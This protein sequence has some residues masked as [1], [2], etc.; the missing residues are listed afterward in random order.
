MDHEGAARNPSNDSRTWSLEVRTTGDAAAAHADK[1]SRYGL[2]TESEP[3]GD[4][5][6]GLKDFNLSPAGQEQ[7]AES[8]NRQANPDCRSSLVERAGPPVNWIDRGMRWA[9]AGHIDQHVLLELI[10]KAVLPVLMTP[11][12][13]P[14]T[15]Q[16]P[17]GPRLTAFAASCLVPD[18]VRA[19]PMYV[20]RLLKALPPDAFLVVNG[21]AELQAKFLVADLVAALRDIGLLVDNPSGG[22]DVGPAIWVE[23]SARLTELVDEPTFDA[24]EQALARWGK[25]SETTVPRARQIEL[26][27]NAVEVLVQGGIA[28]PDVLAATAAFRGVE[29]LYGGSRTIVISGDEETRAR[30]ILRSATSPREPSSDVNPA[31]AEVVADLVYH[32]YVEHLRAMP[33]Q[34][35]A[36]VLAN[37]FA[38]AIT[39]WVQADVR[40]HR[41]SEL[42]IELLTCAKD[43]P[44]ELRALFAERVTGLDP[45]RPAPYKLRPEPRLSITS[46]DQAI[47]CAREDLGVL[48]DPVHVED[49]GPAYLVRSEADASQVYFVH[50]VWETVTIEDDRRG[51]ARSYCIKYDVF[52]LD[53]KW[54][55][56]RPGFQ[57][58]PAPAQMPIGAP[59]QVGGPMQGGEGQTDPSRTALSDSGLAET[60]ASTQQDADGD[61][62]ADAI[63]APTLIG[64]YSMASGD[65]P[66]RVAEFRWSTEAGVTVEVFDQE[67]GKVA[68]YHYHRGVSLVSEKRDVLPSEGPEFMRALLKRNDMSYYRFVDESAQD[69]PVSR[70][71]G[72]AEVDMSQPQGVEMTALEQAIARFSTGQGPVEDVYREFLVARTFLITAPDSSPAYFRIA[73]QPKEQIWVCTD[74]SAAPDLG[75]PE[76]GPTGT[77]P[78][79][80]YRLLPLLADRNVRILTRGD[81]MDLMIIGSRAV[82]LS[83]PE[84][85]DQ[86]RAEGLKKPGTW[87][88]VPDRMLREKPWEGVPERHVVGEY[89]VDENGT[90][91]DQYRPNPA[92]RPSPRTLGFPEPE[93]RLEHFLQLHVTD[94]I[95][96][97]TLVKVL[98]QS[99]IVL[100]AHE[101]GVPAAFQLGDRP[102][103]V[104]ASASEHIPGF[105]KGK[106]KAT[107]AEMTPAFKETD[108][109]IDLGTRHQTHLP[110]QLLLEVLASLEQEKP[111]DAG[112]QRPA[113]TPQQPAQPEPAPK[114]IDPQERFMGAMLAGAVGDALGYAV[115]FHD[116]DLI[117]R[118]HGDAGLTAP[119]LRDGSAHISDDTQM[120]LFTLEGLIRAHV[121]RRMNPVDNDP[122]PEVQHAYQRWFHTQNQPWAQAG[123]P[124]ARHLQQPDGWLITNRELFS[125][126]A[127]GSTCM[128]A[129]AR[130]AQTHQHA[131]LQNPVNDSK[132]CGGVMRAAPVAVWS[133]D[134][135]EVFHA[136]VGTAALTHSHPSG[137]LSAGV[138]A[139]IVHQLIRDVPLPDSVRLARELLLRWRGHEEQVQVLDKAV[140]LAQQGPVA[141]EVIKDTLGQGWVGEEALAIGLYAALATDNLRD[142]LLLSVNHSGDS[143]STG[144]V[145]GN[146]AG[147]LHG[148]RAV[149]PEWLASLELRGVI[150]AL[151]RDALAE[152]SPGPPT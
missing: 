14:M 24:I 30:A 69:Q 33:W 100:A 113:T 68:L 93:S 26:G 119:V 146:I 147:A 25:L 9:M 34:T 29:I 78:V 148:A 61:R 129:L 81:V 104:A 133:N 124:Y 11:D 65:E 57:P 90:V 92:Y 110:G 105:A 121:A 150:E 130:F 66:Q 74:E 63:A 86:V 120:M 41:K 75:M 70:R 98:N 6:I 51:I 117:R 116:I 21:V 55:H 134:P 96:E 140:E 87:L 141:P 38:D 145:C 95:S 144:I 18:D 50:K 72:D 94:Q 123:G 142:A 45:A 32:F 102:T 107:F 58:Q 42:S 47:D 46:P 84:I 7:N 76:L 48:V 43:F 60:P 52:P 99:V 89:W 40:E 85:T 2:F 59:A 12:G 53:P 17:D 1:A 106:V 125:P 4:F 80:G 49:I 44:E 109:V 97:R 127:P 28:D 77:V 108:L 3:G 132:G 122:V 73:D 5:P 62:P 71:A 67:W 10:A 151:A 19:K 149:P 91:T 39:P 139:V 36:V 56:A 82:L 112:Q 22:L 135:A 128:S 88:G 79:N 31:R 64:V 8:A 13:H 27:I 20:P 83:A 114:P 131:T 152:F 37:R 54:E 103:L 115:E 138:L 137:Y 23:Q 15:L 126:R 118:T 35:R 111:S 101:D 16:D 143:D 136:A